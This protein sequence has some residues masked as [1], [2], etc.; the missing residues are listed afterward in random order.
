MG[1]DVPGAF[2]D[3]TVEDRCI[4]ADDIAGKGNP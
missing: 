3:K 4:K 1:G 2:N